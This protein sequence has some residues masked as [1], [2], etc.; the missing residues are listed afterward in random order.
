M[1]ALRLKRTESRPSGASE[2]SIPRISFT[3]NA[4]GSL[5]TV[6]DWEGGQGD[7]VDSAVAR[8]G[9]CGLGLLVPQVSPVEGAL[10]ADAAVDAL[11]Q[12]IGVAAVPR[13]LRDLRHQ[14]I[15]K[16]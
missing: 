12:E 16:L 8:I 11:A 4:R 14:D 7:T 13:V 15:A 6:K 10:L 3:P 1:P 5:G 9:I 2:A